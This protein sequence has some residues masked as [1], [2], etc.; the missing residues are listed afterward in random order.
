M[1]R[2]TDTTAAVELGGDTKTLTEDI[3]TG[4]GSAKITLRRAN[5]Q[6]HTAELHVVR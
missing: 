6:E 3:E 2:I 4:V 1:G 5:A